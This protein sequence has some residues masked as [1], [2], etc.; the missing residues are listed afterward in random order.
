MNLQIFIKDGQNHPISYVQT[1]LDL[2][3]DIQHNLARLGFNPGA[4]N[5]I[6]NPKIQN[7]LT[8]FKAA[9][10]L[11]HNDF[12]IQLAQALLQPNVKAVRSPVMAGKAAKVPVTASSNGSQTQQRPVPPPPPSRLH[13]FAPPPPPSFISKLPSNKTT[14]LRIN[15]EGLKIIKECEDLKLEATLCL[16]GVPVIGYSS[17]RQAYLG[18]TITAKQAE[19]LLLK[20][21][22]LVEAAVSRLVKVP[23]S[24]NQ[25]SALASFV[26]NVGYTAFRSSTLLKLLNQRDYDGAAK[27]FLR[28]DKANGKFW[29][30]LTRR[31]Q[32][33]RALFLT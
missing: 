30:E 20:D 3:R 31:R 19:T 9:H 6:W 27:Q 16:I 17:V 21:L 25:F 1:N 24:D 26:F 33:E 23:L 15:A 7:A 5:G 22:Q 4:T 28:W 29:P 2:V 12:T 8:R 11:F 32:L 13:S 14:T 18:Q 10:Q